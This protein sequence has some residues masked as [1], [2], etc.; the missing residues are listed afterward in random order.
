MSE[1]KQHTIKLY[2]QSDKRKLCHALYSYSAKLVFSTD[3]CRFIS[4]PEKL[5]VKNSSILIKIL[6][7]ALFHQ[8]LHKHT[9][10]H[11]RKDCKKLWSK[12]CD[13]SV[14][15]GICILIK[16][17]KLIIQIIFKV[18]HEFLN[19]VSEDAIWLLVKIKCNICMHNYRF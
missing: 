8:E 19:L 13:A 9:H 14:C 12:E 3:K 15:V 5:R 17:I 7:T 2:L 6:S 4:V 1:T 16:L 10:I 18:I 11:T